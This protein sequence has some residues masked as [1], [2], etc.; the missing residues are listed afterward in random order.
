MKILSMDLI[1]WLEIFLSF[2]NIVLFAI[3]LSNRR[4]A[5]HAAEGKVFVRVIFENKDRLLSK[6]YGWVHGAAFSA[7]V[8][9]NRSSTITF[10][11]ENAEED[12]I[13]TTDVVTL[14]PIK[15]GW[16]IVWYNRL[17]V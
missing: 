13:Y 11:L 16:R 6:K 2:S 14:T 4:Y 9:G 8:S 5:Y 15:R 7:I 3:W 17:K 10:R 12:I 1:L